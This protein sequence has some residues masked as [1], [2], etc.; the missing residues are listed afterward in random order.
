MRCVQSLSTWQ[1]ESL[2]RPGTSSVPHKYS[3]NGQLLEMSTFFLLP[4]RR[5]GWLSTRTEGRGTGPEV[6]PWPCHRPRA[7][8]SAFS[9]DSSRNR[10]ESS[11]PSFQ[12]LITKLRVSVF[13]FLFYFVFLTEPGLIAQAGVQWPNLSSLQP[14]PPR[15]KQI[16]CLSLQSSWDYR[17]SPQCPANFCIFSRDGVL[18]CWPGWSQTPN[19]VIHPPRPPKVLGLQA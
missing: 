15:F 7:H 9:V 4:Q 2:G 13:W 19:L 3:L 6:H 17:C 12:F 5:V 8:L 16:S 1:G 14:L 10:V 18:P 11:A